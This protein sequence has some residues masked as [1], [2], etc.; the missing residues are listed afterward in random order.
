M[1]IKM[2]ITIC[3]LQESLHGFAK[4]WQNFAFA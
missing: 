3:I 2:K 4:E 1:V